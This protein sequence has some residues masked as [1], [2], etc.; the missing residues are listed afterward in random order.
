M[1]K[2][3]KAPSPLILKGLTHYPKGGDVPFHVLQRSHCVSSTKRVE[4]FRGDVYDK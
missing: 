1:E 2:I 4:N 3:F